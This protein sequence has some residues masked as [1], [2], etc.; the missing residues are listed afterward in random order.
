MVL[1]ERALLLLTILFMDIFKAKRAKL[2][3]FITEKQGRFVRQE[4]W[5]DFRDKIGL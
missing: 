4:R 5:K 1:K 3:P 2:E